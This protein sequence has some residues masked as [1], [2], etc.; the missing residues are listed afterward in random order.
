MNTQVLCRDCSL[1]EVKMKYMKLYKITQTLIYIRI[2][3]GGY[4]HR[5][6]KMF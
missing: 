4:C 5:K 1:Y 6:G 3:L 2:K